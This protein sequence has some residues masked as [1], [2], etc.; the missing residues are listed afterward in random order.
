MALQK[1]WSNGLGWD[2]TNAYYRVQSGNTEHAIT[3]VIRITV[4]VFKTAADAVKNEDGD[5]T[6]PPIGIANYKLP[7]SDSVGTIASAYTHL[8][9]LSEFSEATDV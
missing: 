8:K 1:N 5:F 4:A 7:Y 3:D 2:V 6:A 9:T